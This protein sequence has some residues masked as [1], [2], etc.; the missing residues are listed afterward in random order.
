[1]FRI[2]LLQIAP[3]DSVEANLNI[4]IKACQKAKILGADLALFPEMWSVGYR[5]EMVFPRFAVDIDSGYIQSF[6]KTAKKL[7]MAIAVTA[8]LKGNK[9]PR[10]SMILINSSGEIAMRYDKVHVCSFSDPEC[11]LEAG[12]EFK[13]VN[14]KINDGVVRLGAMICYDREF[15]ESART[16]ALMGAEVIITSNACLLKDDK[17]V[18][19]ARIAQFRSRAF[20]NMVGVAMANYPAPFN[21]YSCAF[22]V[23]GR[24]L[25]VPASEEGVYVVDFDL[26][27]IRNWQKSEIWGCKYSRPECY[28]NA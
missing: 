5:N 9:R 21:G 27:K 23:D 17:L 22:D 2:A 14:L 12:N 8:M 16:L 11:R 10:D 28:R 18:K 1:M 19:D 25:I 7:N 15:P 20:E 26:N 4:G 6:K 24:S 13:V 3:G